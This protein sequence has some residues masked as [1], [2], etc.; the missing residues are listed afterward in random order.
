MLPKSVEAVLVGIQPLSVH[1]Q[2][3]WDVAFTPADAPAAPT[4]ARIGPESVDPGLVPGDRILVDSLF[5]I[6]SRIRRAPG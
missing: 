6:V 1:G 4:I 3:I 2:V 5:G